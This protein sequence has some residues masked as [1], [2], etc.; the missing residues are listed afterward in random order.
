MEK[1]KMTW[2]EKILRPGN[3]IA[4]IFLFFSLWIN[5]SFHSASLTH[6]Q[7]ANWYIPRTDLS[8]CLLFVGFCALTIDQIFQAPKKWKNLVIPLALWSFLIFNQSNGILK[9]MTQNTLQMKPGELS[10][11]PLELAAYHGDLTEVKNLAQRGADVRAQNQVN[12]TAL[13]FACGASPIVNQEYKGSPEVADYLI[14]RGADVNS[15]D[16]MGNTP[17]MDAISNHNLECVR[18]LLHHKADINLKSR[19][20][21]TAFSL[22]QKYEDPAIQQELLKSQKPSSN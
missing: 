3:G 19:Y 4:F 2:K 11:S 12:K 9:H 21:S 17:L 1:Q 8:F 16:S 22:A 18:I 15:Q 7:I 14:S 5:P 10:L 13:H 20:G 6:F